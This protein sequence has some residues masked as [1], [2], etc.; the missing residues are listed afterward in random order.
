MTDRLFNR[1][2]KVET[3]VKDDPL[4]IGGFGG[5]KGGGNPLNFRHGQV[6]G[7]R[8]FFEFRDVGEVKRRW[9]C[10]WVYEWR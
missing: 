7:E 5:P 8:H 4:K 10:A 1:G 3:R 9:Y 6:L 2:Y